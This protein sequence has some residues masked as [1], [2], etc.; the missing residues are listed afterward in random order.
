MGTFWHTL[1]RT[2]RVKLPT[3]LIFYDCETYPETYA[4]G[5]QRHTLKVGYAVHCIRH[6]RSMK[7]TETWLKITS[8]KVF[9]DFV[10]KKAEKKA[11]LMLIA[12]QQHFDFMVL[13]G[14]SELVER[15]WEL[16]RHIIT[17]NLFIAR[18]KKESKTIMVVDSLNW[19]RASI[20]Q[21]GEALGTDKGEIDFEKCS[22]AELE[23]YCK[24]DVK[25]LKDSVLALIKFIRKYRLGNFQ[26]TRAS[27]AFSTYKH[28]FM[29]FKLWIHAHYKAQELER[30]SY[31]GGRNEAYILGEVKETIYDFDVNSLYPFVM[32]KEEYPTKFIRYMENTSVEDLTRLLTKY[33]VIAKVKIHILEPFIALKQERL[34]F[35][36]G[37]FWVTLTTPELLRVQERGLILEV[38]ELSMYE[39]APIFKK[40]VT[41][42][43]K[44]RLMFK[45]AANK[46]FEELTKGLL[47]SLYG[48]FG[49][50]VQPLKEVGEAPIDEISVTRGIVYETNVVFTEYSF[51]GKVYRR[52]ST[53]KEWHDSFPAIASHVTAYARMYLYDLMVLAGR[54]NVFYGNTD[55][56]FVNK[57]GMLRLMDLIHENKLGYLK[58]EKEAEGLDVRG[59]K[60]YKIGSIEKIKGIK[61]DAKQLSKNVYEQT[62]FYKFRSLLRK[63]LL[64]APLTEIVTKTLKREYKKGTLLPNGEVIPF[65]LS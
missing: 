29:E 52:Q 64:D 50:K 8:K 30:L 49:Q 19:L 5:I 45:A 62:R 55:S 54:E 10:E 9:W 44:L 38:G 65:V 24:Q 43:Y 41:H 22:L 25:I 37:T 53:N 17:S 11:R 7:W 56:L 42:L 3:R 18:F 14:F 4:E 39:K 13:D 21:L 28:R 59:C 20:A 57:I 32:Q 47:N 2:S 40:W 31:R 15:G 46:V 1:R 36:V 16:K 12:H 35:P 58:L 60:D 6:K 48:K 61:K 27:Q 34:I 23:V 33:L 51:G 63:G 26:L